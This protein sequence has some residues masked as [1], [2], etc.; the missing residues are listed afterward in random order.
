MIAIIGEAGGSY[1]SSDFTGA[2]GT[3]SLTVTSNVNLHTFM[4]GVRVRA[5]NV[6]RLV[7][8]GQILFGGEHTTNSNETVTV[9]QTTSRIRRDF[10]STDAALAFDAGA[11]FVVRSR[12]GVRAAAGYAHFFAPDIDLNAFRFSLGA[13]FRF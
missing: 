9:Q 6:P 2:G 3:T 7:P 8:F 4:G 10:A 11:T 12:V 1:Y 5:S 13:A